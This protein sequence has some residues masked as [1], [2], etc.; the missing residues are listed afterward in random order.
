MVYEIIEGNDDD[1]NDEG[2][3]DMEA[4]AGT[5]ERRAV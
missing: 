3:I 2:V 4:N 5:S 1:N